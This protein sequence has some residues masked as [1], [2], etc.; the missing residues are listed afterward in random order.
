[1]HVRGARSEGGRGA[2]IGEAQEERH[3]GGPVRARDRRRQ[4]AVVGRGGLNVL[5]DRDAPLE[6]HARVPLAP[7]AARDRADTR[8]RLLE[9]RAQ[10]ADLLLAAVE[11]V[12]D[13]AVVLRRVREAEVMRVDDLVDH[14]LAAVE[15]L[16]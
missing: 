6:R 3:R 2:P 16:L 13:L 14:G 11:E 7:E 9:R 8:V 12:Q 10:R 4:L 15:L 5:E 1:M